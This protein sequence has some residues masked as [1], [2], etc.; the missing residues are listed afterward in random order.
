[1]LTLIFTIIN[2]MKLREIEYKLKYKNEQEQY[3]ENKLKDFCTKNGDEIKKVEK[4]NEKE[5][6]GEAR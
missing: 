1:M 5:S 6:E 3:L 2:Y 4:Q